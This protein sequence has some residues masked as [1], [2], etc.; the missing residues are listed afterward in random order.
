MIQSNYTRTVTSPAAVDPS[1]LAQW[2]DLVDVLEDAARACDACCDL[3]EVPDP[4]DLA[5]LTD[6]WKW[7]FDGETV[8]SAADRLRMAAP[9]SLPVSFPVHI[10]GPAGRSAETLAALDADP[11]PLLERAWQQLVE[12][13]DDPANVELLVATLALADAIAQVRGRY[14]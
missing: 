11:L 14:E 12:L 9:A 8:R 6:Q 4:T 2:Q 13:P 10:V 5:A 7:R 1:V 3:V